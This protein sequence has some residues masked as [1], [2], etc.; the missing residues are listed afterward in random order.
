MSFML[1]FSKNLDFFLHFAFAHLLLSRLNDERADRQCK[2][3]YENEPA[4]VSPRWHTW[5]VTRAS[6]CLSI[7]QHFRRISGRRKLHSTW[8]HKIERALHCRRSRCIHELHSHGPRHD[9]NNTILARS[10]YN[11]LL[12]ITKSSQRGVVICQ[13]TDYKHIIKV[14]TRDQFFFLYFVYKQVHVIGTWFCIST[15]S[16]NNRFHV[17]STC[18]LFSSCC[19][20]RSSICE[21][22]SRAPC[23]SA[24]SHLL[25]WL[26]C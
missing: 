4:S 24:A 21:D 8:L 10:R 11:F 15:S 22:W 17:H 20:F 7:Y 14:Q 3:K 5:Q 2:N 19:C 18:A 25:P 9:N 13:R 6:V 23:F 12:P 1:S 16:G 26:P